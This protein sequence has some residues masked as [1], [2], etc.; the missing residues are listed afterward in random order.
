MD[1]RK[2]KERQHEDRLHTGEVADI[3]KISQQTVIRCFDSGKLK[4]CV[5][6]SRFIPREACWPL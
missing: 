2:G 4:G 6:G 3:C 1:D 5:P